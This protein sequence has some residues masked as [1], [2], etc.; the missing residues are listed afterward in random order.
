M[1]RVTCEIKTRVQECIV[2]HENCLKRFKKPW[3]ASFNNSG[4]AGEGEGFLVS[5]SD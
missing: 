5:P 2:D 4:Q 1:L 3:A